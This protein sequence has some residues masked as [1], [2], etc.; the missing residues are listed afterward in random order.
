MSYVVSSFILYVRFPS[1]I[2]ELIQHNM[3]IK[4]TTVQI[5]VVPRTHRCIQLSVW[6]GELVQIF[7]MIIKIRICSFLFGLTLL[8]S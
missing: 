1:C 5:T 8:K 7:T 2:L 3:L 4:N 6:K